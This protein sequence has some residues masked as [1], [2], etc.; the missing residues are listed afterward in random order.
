M[1]PYKDDKKIGTHYKFR[2]DGSL[3]STTPYEDGKL[4]GVE[5]YYDAETGRL[6]CEVP[7]T[8]NQY[9]GEYRCYW[10]DGSLFRCEIYDMGHYVGS[11]MP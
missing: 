11:C 9:N 1:G 4:N 8:D 5:K 10:D 2:E 6:T 3:S 7:Y